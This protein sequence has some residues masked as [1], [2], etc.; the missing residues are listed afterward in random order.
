MYAPSRLAQHSA[1]VMPGWAAA[2]RAAT[3]SSL[4][5]APARIRVS[6]SS[7]FTS[8]SPVYS[9]SRNTMRP[10]VAASPS[11][12]RA[13]TGPIT[14]S[15]AGRP[16]RA[17]AARAA[18]S[19]EAPAGVGHVVVEADEQQVALAGG[20]HERR[21]AGD[22]PAGQPSDRRARPVEP[23]DQDVPGAVLIQQ[24]G[25]DLPPPGHLRR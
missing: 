23:V 18:S 6:S 13:G 14:P 11:P 8:R 17:R 10:A 4:I 16:R 25:Q 9:R 24:G 21:L 22:R 19:A 7:D 1:S 3:A 15:R 20:E 12:A 2:A 5:A